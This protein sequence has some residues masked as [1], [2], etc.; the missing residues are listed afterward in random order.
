MKTRRTV[1]LF[2]LIT[3]LQIAIV[4]ALTNCG[5]EDVLPE[6]DKPELTEDRGQPVGA[7]LPQTV[8]QVYWSKDSKEI[9]ARCSKGVYAINIG[10]DSIRVIN[11]DLETVYA[12]YSADGKYLFY[13]GKG[14]GKNQYIIGRLDMADGTAK[15]LVRSAIAG[16]LIISQD[17]ELMAFVVG[18]I[19]DP[20]IFIYTE[21]TGNIHPFVTGIPRS[22]NRDG[23]RMIVRDEKEKKIY[24]IDMR[25]RSRVDLKLD[26]IYKY[27]YFWNQDRIFVFAN[28]RIRDVL[29]NTSRTTNLTGILGRS[30]TR[31]MTF[32]YYCADEVCSK[33]YVTYYLI[34]DNPYLKKQFATAIAYNF[35]YP[36]FAPDEEHAAYIIN[37]SIYIAK[38]PF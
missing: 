31:S 2:V 3:L 21:S 12:S 28:G 19:P 1:Y 5:R 4:T 13:F 14:D 30:W 11:E 25:D 35:G 10:T 26:M 16:P 37:S 7:N 38:L 27:K 29:N 18:D 33:Y 15:T 32:D 22:F 6:E 36:T 34:N 9:I 20:S 8:K 17:H 23:T 24:L